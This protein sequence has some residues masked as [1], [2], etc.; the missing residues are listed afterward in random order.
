MNIA[1]SITAASL[2]ALPEPRFG[3]AAAFM[4]VDTDTGQRQIV[5]NPAVDAPGGAGV[6]AAE[7]IVQHGA[8]A[9]I[10]GS[11]GPKASDVLSAAG[12]SMIRA[13]ADSVDELLSQ[14]QAGGDQ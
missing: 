3:R 4:L 8:E 6:R 12:I 1:I 5:A 2:D 11:F 13:Q 14:Y 7:C 9:V 10:S